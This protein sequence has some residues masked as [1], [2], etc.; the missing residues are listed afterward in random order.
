MIE[1]T[2]E[3]ERA[4]ARVDGV[5]RPSLTRRVFPGLLAAAA[6]AGVLVGD[7]W[8]SGTAWEPFIQLGFAVLPGVVSS[9]LPISAHAVIGLF[10]HTL[11]LVLWGYCFTV[12]ARSLRGGKVFIAAVIVTAALFIVARVIFPRVL[13]AAEWALMSSAHALLYLVT[14]A[15]AFTIGT[16]LARYA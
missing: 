15:V 5:A 14:I 3:L 11:L 2:S 6:S 10:V 13:G 7:G 4:R 16:R 12:V 8:R 9:L 1:E